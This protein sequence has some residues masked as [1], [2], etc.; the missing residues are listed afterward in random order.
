MAR[1]H[2]LFEAL[3]QDTFRPGEL[4]PVE[5]LLH[6]AFEAGHAAIMQL[7]VADGY[8]HG[9]PDG[10]GLYLERAL[11]AREEDVGEKRLGGDGEIAQSAATQARDG[12]CP[13]YELAS[14]PSTGKLRRKLFSV[15]CGTH[16]A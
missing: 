8:P 13:G 11:L 12:A 14:L 10:F 3:D 7:G 15:R 2:R 1:A 5:V 16:Y 4:V 6:D 9:V